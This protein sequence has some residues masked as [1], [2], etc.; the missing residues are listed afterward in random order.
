M[1]P[2]EKGK[3]EASPDG[4]RRSTVPVLTGAQASASA[5]PTTAPADEAAAGVTLPFSNAGFKELKLQLDRYQ[6]DLVSESR[7]I[8]RRHQA[9]VISPAY[10]RHARDHLGTSPRRRIATLAGSIGWAMAGAAFPTLFRL[11][12]SVQAASS[13]QVWWNLIGMVGA[14]LITVQFLRE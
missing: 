6:A 13:Q 14:I 10:V 8:A 12:S 11:D 2:P 7:R 1:M 4:D 9:D 5:P 3:P